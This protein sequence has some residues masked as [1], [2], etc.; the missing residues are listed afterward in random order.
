[1]PSKCVVDLGMAGDRLPLASGWVPVDV[2]PGTVAV[3][4]ASSP[5]KLPDQLSTPHRAISFT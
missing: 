4:Y 3:E 1:M 2:M 5:L